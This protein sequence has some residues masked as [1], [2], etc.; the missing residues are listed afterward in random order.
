MKVKDIANI[1]EELAP[2]NYQENYDNAGLI[3]GNENQKVSGIIICLDSTEKVVNE[4]IAKKCNLIIAHHPIIFNGL[5]KITGKNYIEKTIIK[6]IKNNIAIYAAHTNLDN[7][8]NGV[9]FKMAQ[10][11]Q[12]INCKILSPKKSDFKKIVTFC[13]TSYHEQVKN[14]MFNAG[15]GNIGNYDNCSFNTIGKGTFRAG[16]N[17]KPFIGKKGKVHTEDEIKIETIVTKHMV[18]KV[19]SELIKAHPYEEVAYDIYPLENIN[20]KVGSG[21][22][23]ELENTMDENS[24]LKKIKKNLKT[25]CIRHTNVLGKPVKRVALCGGAGS[26][27]L[28]D[29][30]IQNADVFITGDFKYHQFF[31]AENKILIADIGHYESEQFTNELFYEILIKKITNFAV[32]LS[33]INTNP[34]NYL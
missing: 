29:A 16:K 19:I 4:A 31:D 5:K 33:E 7:A 8:F 28:N 25:D 13:P 3:V 11:L 10:K 12:L 9:S 30:I 17:T 32:H 1:I 21:V 24:F 6:A 26:F 20:P 2:I 14:A 18:N 27:L 15:A 23:G 22:I 34:I